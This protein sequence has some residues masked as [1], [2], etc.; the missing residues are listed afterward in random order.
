MKNVRRIVCLLLVFVMALG[1][2]AGCG[3]K[4]TESK[5]G[6]GK[7]T[8]GVPQDATIPDYDT[9]GLSVYLEEVTGL[10]IEWVYFASG[11]ANYKQQ[12]TLMCTGGEALPD[13]IVGMDGL[14]HYVVNQFGEDGYI[15]D[16][17]QLIA[18]GKA[19]NYEK[20]LSGLSKDMQQYVK[21]KGTNTTDGESFYAMPTV[22]L[23]C[24]DDLQS[25]VYINKAWLSAVGM[26]APTNIRELEAVCQAFLTKDPNGN[27]SQDEMPMLGGA[28]LRYWV[29]NA[30]VEYDAGNFNVANGKVW[31][32]VTSDEFRQ[33]L[34][35]V[36][37]LV[38]KGYFNELGFT[39]SNTEIK[40]LISPTDGSAGRVGIFAGH[41]ESMTNASTDVLNDYI[42]LAPLADETGKGGYCVVNEVG[43]TWDGM[44][45]KDCADDDEAIKFLDAFYLDECVTRQRHGVKDVDWFEEK[46]KNAYGTESYARCIN[47]EAF[48]DGS[49]NCTLGNLLGIMTHWNYLL[50]AETA[51]T[52]DNNRIV[53]ASRLQTEQWDVRENKGKKREGILDALIYTTKEYETR[54]EKAGNVSS[55]VSEQ[56]VL[57][58]KGEKDVSDDKAW[59]E[60]KSTLNSLGRGEMMKIAQDAYDRKVERQ[61]ANK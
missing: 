53:Q 51:E 46:G 28:S 41:H 43:L 48:F 22:G 44:I 50:V 32:P 57:F 45:T 15:K 21:E 25:M 34:K 3:K 13:V 10:D 20:A 60:F 11:S 39:L 24:V 1:L 37:G 14:G 18:D 5:A 17:S 33:S 23:E 31:D 54:E 29:I 61:E 4:Q 42:A 59:N 35:Y 56:T 9:N 8:V 36:N 38:E 6:D 40:N 52:S 55:Y 49:L 27:G 16:L 30:F 47:S 12:L 2:F 58:M 19:P 7:I 26:Q